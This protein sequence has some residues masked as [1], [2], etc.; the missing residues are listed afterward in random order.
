MTNHLRLALLG[1][2]RLEAGQN[3]HGPDI[4]EDGALSWTWWVVALGVTIRM[5]MTIVSCVT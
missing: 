2:E 5:I 1:L 4:S 3:P